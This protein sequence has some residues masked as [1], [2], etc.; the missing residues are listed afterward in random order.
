[1]YASRLKAVIT[2]DT[3]GA[4]VVI[5][6]VARAS[7]SPSRRYSEATADR[8]DCRTENAGAR[9]AG[10]ETRDGAQRAPGSRARVRERRSGQ[11]RVPGPLRSSSRVDRGRRAAPG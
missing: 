8:D 5:G 2:T 11:P 1:M 7:G 4:S 10:A 6:A 9:S 3:A